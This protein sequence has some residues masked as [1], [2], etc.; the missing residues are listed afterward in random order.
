MTAT[1]MLVVGAGATGGYFGGRLA[2]AGRDVTFLVRPARRDTL[3]KDGLQIAAPGG[4]STVRPKLI[5]KNE[6]DGAYDMVLLTVK[7]FALEPAIA[8]MRPAVGP[9]T[10][11][12]PTLNGMRHLDT[13]DAAFSPHNVMGCL[14]KIMGSIDE[15]GRIVQGT[16]MNDLV[17]GERDGARSKRAEDIDAF[18][19]GA[20]FDARLSTAIIPEMWAKWVML[21]SLGAITCLMRGD[22]GQVS[23]AKDGLATASRIIDEIAA[24]VAKVGATLPL[25]AL[26]QIRGMMTDP[27]S[28][29]TSSMYR[30]LVSGQPVE[31]E[32]ILGDLIRRGDEA[33]I[34][35]PLVHAATVSLRIYEAARQ[36]KAAR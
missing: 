35:S 3:V 11:I 22:I 34:D 25:E 15:R 7:A 31:V 29:F 30:D 21:A 19:Q 27:K 24:I 36:A 28:R 9:E 33:G 8:D 10:A 14:A 4:V 20:G 1:R 13:L 18:M 26:A 5:L 12:L 16:A 32:Q 23:S 6:I 2:E 17:Y